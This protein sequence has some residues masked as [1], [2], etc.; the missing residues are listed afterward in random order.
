MPLMSHRLG[1]CSGYRLI[2]H[3]IFSQAPPQIQP[4]HG[5]RKR[6]EEKK[7]RHESPDMRISE[8]GNC[9]ARII[10]GCVRCCG[11]AGMMN[12][13]GLCLCKV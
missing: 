12:G 8:G 13:N 11:C 7:K 9:G 3:S 5:L 1:S 4:A 6:K 2:T 10:E